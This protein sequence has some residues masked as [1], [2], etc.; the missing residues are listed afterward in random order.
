MNRAL[1]DCQDHG[2]TYCEGCGTQLS[3]EIV[4]NHISVDGFYQCNCGLP[5]TSIECNP[6][7]KECPTG[8]GMIV[9]KL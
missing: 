8:E 4:M 7:W 9:I 6:E 3:T 2:I 1:F 5:I